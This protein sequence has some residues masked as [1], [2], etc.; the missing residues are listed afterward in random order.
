VSPELSIIIVNWNTRPLL[1]AA[2]RQLHAAAEGTPWEAFVVDNA[3]SD[4]SAEMVSGNF[5]TVGLIQNASNEG[6]G[7]ACNRALVAASGRWLLLLNADTSLTREALKGMIRFM[8]EHP[9]AGLCGPRLNRD[10]GQ[11]QA[12]AFGDDPSL[13]Y[14]LKRKLSR[15]ALGKPLHNWSETEARSVDWVSGACLL[16]RREA[17]DQVGGF[18]PG[19]FLYFEDNDW[20]LR[21]RKA[22]WRVYHVPGVSVKHVHGRS[23]CQ[24]PDAPRHYRK[25]L[26]HFHAKHYGALSCLMLSGCL[27]VDRM[28]RR[29]GKA[30]SGDESQ[31]DPKPTRGR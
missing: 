18:D 31:C 21:M 29:T 23:V 8:G 14:L 4:G 25:S 7:R 24:N 13:W 30:Y 5:P 2:L 6:Y 15:I 26:A 9:D 16:A 3:S 11:A 27:F 28:F 1:D 10:D 17:V 22:G 20:C 12:Y 19:I